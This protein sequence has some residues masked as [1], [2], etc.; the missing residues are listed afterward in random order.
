MFDEEESRTRLR[1]WVACRR[2]HRPWV[3]GVVSVG[4]LLSCSAEEGPPETRRPRAIDVN[5]LEVV[6]G[7][8]DRGRTPQVVALDIGGEG[9]CSGVIVDSR[10]VLTARHCVSET[11]T[12]PQCPSQQRQIYRDRNPATLRVFVGDDIGQARFVARGVTIVAPPSPDLCGGDIALLVLD[13][14]IDAIVP[15][16]VSRTGIALGSYVRAVGFGRPGDEEPAGRKLLREHVRVREVSRNEYL[17][18]ESTCGGDSGG[19]AFDEETGDVVGI[20]SRGGPRCEGRDAHNVYTR[21][22]AFVDLVDMAKAEAAQNVDA[23]SGKP[24]KTPKPTKPK[25]DVGRACVDG[26]E[27][28]TGVCVGDESRRYCSRTCGPGD[29]CPAGFHCTKFEGRESVCIEKP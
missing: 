12:H 5:S 28:A 26:G 17:V 20:V 21:V 10:V 7:V 13:R 4:G 22:D 2:S 14:P 24:S 8:P 25:S 11:E 6:R 23:S 16:T 15:S 19:P 27:C 29:R 9:L 18:G 1:R 3:I